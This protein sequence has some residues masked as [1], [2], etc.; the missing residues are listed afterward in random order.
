MTEWLQTHVEKCPDFQRRKTCLYSAAI[1]N[2]LRLSSRC[3]VAASGKSLD[4]ICSLSGSFASL[5]YE[6]YVILEVVT[7]VQDSVLFALTRTDFCRSNLIGCVSTDLFS[8]IF[9]NSRL[10]TGVC[11]VQSSYNSWSFAV[12][13]NIVK[14]SITDKVRR[15]I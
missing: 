11:S 9:H 13:I 4:W 12:M 2:L 10:N 1:S 14:I 5:F 3:C 6:S 15:P 8:F 7:G